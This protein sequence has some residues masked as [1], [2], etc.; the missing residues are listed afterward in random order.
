ML[1]AMAGPANEACSHGNH[2]QVNAGITQITATACYAKDF[3]PSSR[4]HSVSYGI[5]TSIHLCSDLNHFATSAESR[6]QLT[7]DQEGST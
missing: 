6:V 5:S 3:L 1:L 2:V 7:A 4:T